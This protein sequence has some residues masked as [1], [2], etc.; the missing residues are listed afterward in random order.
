MGMNFLETIY[1][2][3]KTGVDHVRNVCVIDRFDIITEIKNEVRDF[4]GSLC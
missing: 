4:I 3:R 2:S 1:E